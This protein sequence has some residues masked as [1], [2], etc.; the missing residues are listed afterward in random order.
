MFEGKIWW[1]TRASSGIGAALAEALSAKGAKLILSGRNVSALEH[2]KARLKTDVLLLP[3]E[4]TDS[5]RYRQLPT[6]R[7]A[8]AVASMV[9]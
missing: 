3:F 5:A 7:G 9:S 8:G 4:A 1:I 2:V 6:M